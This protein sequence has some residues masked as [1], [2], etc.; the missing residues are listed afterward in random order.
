MPRR[1]SALLVAL[2]LPIVLLWL[3]QASIG[4]VQSSPPTPMNDIVFALWDFEGDTTDPAIDL[5]GNASASRGSGLTNEAFVQGYPNFTGRAWS[6][7]G[8]N[9]SAPHTDKYIQFQLD[10]TA[11]SDMRFAFA[12]RRSNTGPLNFIIQYSLDEIV[13]VPITRTETVLITD[14]NWHVQQF[15]FSQWPVVN[16]AISHQPEVSFRIYGYGAS[17]A[18]GTWRIDDVTFSAPPPP[19]PGEPDLALSKVGSATAVAGQLLTYQLAVQNQG[20]LTATQVV[21]TDTL[22]HGLTYLTDDSGL[23]PAEP[24]PGVWVWQL[25]DLPPGAAASFQLTAT[26][27]ANLW[28]QVVNEAEVST[29]VTETNL[30]NNMASFATFIVDGGQPVTL[31]DALYYD[32]Y[33]S[34]QIDEAVR[35]I[36]AGSGAAD[37]SGWQISKGSGSNAVLPAN[38]WLTA[39]Q[40]IWLTRDGAAFA[41]QFGYVPDFAL[42]NAPSGG[43]LGGGWPQFPNDGLVSLLDNQAVIRDLMV[44]GNGNTSQGAHWSGPAVRPYRGGNVFAAKGQILYRMRDQ[45]TGRPV[46]DTNTAL[47]WAQSTADVINGRKIQFPGWRLDDFF[48]TAQITETAVLTVAIA[49]D[50]A[51]A[52]MAAQIASAQQSLQ[53]QSL[54]FENLAIMR[55]LIEAAHRGVSVTVL[56]EG[57]PPGGLPDQGRYVCQ[58]LELAGGACWFM[59]ND[60]GQNIYDRYTYLHAKFIL[61]DGERVIIS[62]EN[63][64]PNSL[65]YDD[66]A[67]GTWGRRGIVLVTDAPG[68]V[69]HVQA[70]FDA[71]FNHTTHVDLFRWQSGHPTWGDPPFGFIPHDESGGITYTVRYPTAVAFHETFAFEIVQSPE[72]SLRDQDGLLGLLHRANAGDII[73]VQQLNER[74]HW[75][76]TSSNPLDD[77]NPRL[78]AY[79]AAARR[80]AAVW[81]LLDAYFDSRTNPVSNYATCQQVNALAQAERL[82]LYCSLGNPAGL[83]IHNKMV[84]AEIDGRG[85]IHAGSLNGS[86]NSHKANRE[87]ALQV[88]SDAAY[89]YLAA[90]F[91]QDWPWTVFLPLTMNNYIGPA[92]HVLISE[93]LYDPFGGT[94]AE[95]FIELV[96]P[97]GAPI[98]LGGYSIGDAANPDDFEDM[99]LF[100][101]GTIIG[102]GQTIVIAL[103]AEAFRAMFFH[104]PDFEILE[105]DPA[106]PTLPKDPHWGHPN[107]LL[108]LVN[109]GD[110]V[111]LRDPAGQLV[112]IVVYGNGHYPG[113]VACPLVGGP[114]RSLERFPYWRTTGHC[115]TDFREQAFPNPGSL[116]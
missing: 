12:H 116:P 26:V 28:G 77:P 3:L 10:L 94:D 49:P 82:N 115:P 83:G 53:I 66:K 102:P 76:A 30:A 15:D 51:Y 9:V 19:P 58:Q 93:V 110:E 25:A 75:G 74:P 7:A 62:S 79:L 61:I 98:D 104:N 14:T 39:G 80:G 109:Q 97:T 103:S 113:V 107:A 72:N 59:I 17:G 32:S 54:T 81:L 22:P 1:I 114:Q 27:A 100:P 21:L 29:A 108:R 31:I 46:A 89:A 105:T 36:N 5:T 23:S 8:W 88:Q 112:D 50:N 86:E 64:S 65:P 33:E 41:R 85:Y 38:T 2:A 52:T 13:F 95:E 111:L 16:A 4:Q 84:L 87:L 60:S 92:P 11:Y 69:A 68:V 71:D 106:V 67:D 48:F 34:G 70:I 40:A 91:F 57:G 90:M 96:N 56:L 63:L 45:A 44:Y 101:P 35:L 20:S 42:T 78:E 55:D 24:A 37:I 73:L 99:R 43:Q 18:S 47:D 6:F